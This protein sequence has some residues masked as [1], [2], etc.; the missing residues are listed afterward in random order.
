MIEIKEFDEI[1]FN[2]T[3]LLMWD[4]DEVEDQPNMEEQLYAQMMG[5]A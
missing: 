5:W 4:A 3:P 2:F 1:S